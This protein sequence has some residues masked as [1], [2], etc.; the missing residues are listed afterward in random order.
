[1]SDGPLRLPWYGTRPWVM[2]I[3]N[4]TPDSFSDGGR[5]DTTE[6]AVARGRALAAQGA[7]IIDV[8]G[9]STRPG[10][11]R[12]DAAEESAR[13]VPVIR[14][15]SAEGI[16]CSVDTTRATVAA[17]AAEA[18]VGLINDVSGGLA[19]P[20]MLDVVAGARL[21]WILMHWRGHSDVMAQMAVYDDVVGEVRDELLRQVEVAV[22]AGIDERSLILDPG[23]GF[24]KNADHNWDLLAELSLLVEH[25]F[26]VLVGASR[27]RFLGE[28]LADADG[29]PRPPAEREAATAA[30][31]MV[32]AEA[33]VWGVRVH[34]PGPT[35][36]AFAVLER[37]AAT[38]PDGGTTRRHTGLPVGTAPLLPDAA[39]QDL[40]V[41]PAQD[42][43]PSTGEWR[44]LI[45]RERTSSGGAVRG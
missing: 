12:V 24:A 11:H 18:G 36:D 45:G 22:A 38:A 5:W 26:P 37:L 25:G 15:L 8:G 42:E 30:V 7:D 17:A 16:L 4:V 23:L 27:K 13:V 31:S 41:A 6:A 21:P 35:A 39:L 19:D 3:L 9:E 29:T 28:L 1:M 43:A 34:E 10:A 33:G 20:G 14:A 32:A 40:L 44:G 2:G